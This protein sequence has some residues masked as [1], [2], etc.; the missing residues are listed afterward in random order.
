MW[1]TSTANVHYKYKVV[2]ITSIRLLH[3][4]CVELSSVFVPR[5]TICL[6]INE[7]NTFKKDLLMFGLHIKLDPLINTTTM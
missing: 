1:S 5:A 6:K 7:I 2:V 3:D 4:V